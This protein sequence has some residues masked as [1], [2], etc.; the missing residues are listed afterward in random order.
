ME[1]WMSL[2]PGL[3]AASVVKIGA[4]IWVYPQRWSQIGLHGLAELIK[5]A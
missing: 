3:Q 2:G 5:S 4:T 1:S